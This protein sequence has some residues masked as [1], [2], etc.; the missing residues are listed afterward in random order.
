MD[1]Q[2]IQALSLLKSSIHRRKILECFGSNVMTPSEISKF[3]TLRLN[4]VSMYLSDLKKAGL[5]ECLNETSKKGRL[6][7]LTELG[8]KALK[9]L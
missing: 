5:L 2:T 6:Y 8:K 1:E 9:L 4:H 7:R 3:T